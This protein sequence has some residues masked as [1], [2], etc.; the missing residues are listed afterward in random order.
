MESFKTIKKIGKG[1]ISEVYLIK[2][3]KTQK[4]YALKAIKIKNIEKKN[5]KK[6][7][8]WSR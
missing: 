1:A 3:K 7:E 2:S 6:N 4:E 8:R 5:Y